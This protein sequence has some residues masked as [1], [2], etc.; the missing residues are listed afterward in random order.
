MTTLVV[1]PPP[2][3]PF[4]SS[5]GSLSSGSTNTLSSSS[6]NADAAPSRLPPPPTVTYTSFDTAKTTIAPRQ[7]FPVASPASRV[8]RSP[9]HRATKSMSRVPSDKGKSRS[10]ASSNSPSIGRRR[11]HRASQSV[12]PAPS[13]ITAVEPS[14]SSSSSGTPERRGMPVR[15]RTLSFSTAQQAF[16]PARP[17]LVQGGASSSAV[18]P[19]PSVDEGKV[20]SLVALDRTS[21]V[22]SSAAAPLRR[23]RPSR[24]SQSTRSAHTLKVPPGPTT[25]G[26]GRGGG[27]ASEYLEA[28]VVILGSQ[29]VG[30][31]SLINRSTT[32][33]FSPSRSSTIGASFL[34]K[35]LTVADTRVHFQ[36]WDA[37]GQERFRALMPLYYRG[38]QAAILVYDVTDEASLQDIKFWIE[39]LRK[40]MSDELMI[41]VVGTKADLAGS[42]PTVPLADAQRSIA[43][44]LHELDH[45]PSEADPPSNPPPA[46]PPLQARNAFPSQAP[47][48]RS[49]TYSTPLS[50]TSIPTITTSVPSAPNSLLRSA[51]IASSSSSSSTATY[52]PPPP[53]PPT[54][55]TSL[56]AR[57]RA[58]S[59]KLVPT[60]SSAAPSPAP[61]PTSTLISSATMPDFS[62]Y[63]LAGLNLASSSSSTVAS[64]SSGAAGAG[65]GGAVEALSMV[66]SASSTSAG[67]GTSG[68]G[69]GTSPASAGSSAITAQ[70]TSPPGG[71][72]AGMTSSASAFGLASIGHSLSLVGAHALGESISAL[73]ASSASRRRQSHDERLRRDWEA[74]AATLRA[75]EVAEEERVR[76]I[77]DACRV[78]VVEVSAKDGWGIEEVFWSVAER[79]VE[80]R[81]EIERRRTLRS[82]DSIVLREEDAAD[83]TKKGWCGC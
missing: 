7:P 29:G 39:E 53:A 81:E 52:A 42:Y 26:R 64:G 2:S 14:A 74:Y 45:P 34:T 31:T 25:A 69:A 5:P 11:G 13:S 60:S 80:R 24:L 20:P 67:A 37:A 33:H 15:S 66:R 48:V 12:S 54:S 70:G 72:A 58:M 68:A 35:K 46:P 19:F 76:D 9:G 71:T 50:S 65:L 41:I 73:G 56:S 18:L 27:D 57:M 16:L 75:R 32:G 62:A 30:K 36:L 21:P 49:R 28:K 79:L 47:L 4:P 17:R 59:N 40:N 61:R 55:D 3:P 44:W 63:T 6:P 82:R 22:G 8:G 83:T 77:V 43:L 1:T 38:A 10:S 51:T 78:E 23:P